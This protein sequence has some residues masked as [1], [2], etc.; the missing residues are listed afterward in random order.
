MSDTYQTVCIVDDDPSVCKALTRLIKL[1]GF[2]VKSYTSAQELLDEK[3]LGSIDLLL[4]DIK[5]PDMNGFALQEHLAVIGF[6][7]SFIFMTAHDDNTTR[8][9][10]MKKDAVAFLQKPFDENDLL[11]AINIGLKLN[12]PMI[13]KKVNW[14]QSL[15][16]T[17]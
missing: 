10:A 5:M 7:I 17:N 16:N 4:L 9:I 1:A 8:T 12:G 13:Q 6:N 11:E 2:K 3:Q 15:D 14:K